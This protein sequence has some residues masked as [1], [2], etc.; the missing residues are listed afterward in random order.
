VVAV[1]FRLY[2]AS[3][4]VVSAPITR[5]PNTAELESDFEDLTRSPRL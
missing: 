1:S 2:R 4:E 3:A 5:W